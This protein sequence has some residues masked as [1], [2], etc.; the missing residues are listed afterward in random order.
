MESFSA[1]EF[2]ALKHRNEIQPMPYFLGNPACVLE[3]FFHHFRERLPGLSV[4]LS[5]FISD[6]ILNHLYAKFRGFCRSCL[7]VPE[8]LE[9]SGNIF[10]LRS[11]S[12]STEVNAAVVYVDTI[13]AKQKVNCVQTSDSGRSHTDISLSK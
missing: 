13:R 3:S 8:P 9:N 1:S 10:I 11:P 4:V 12:V 7:I 6:S 2:D 5:A